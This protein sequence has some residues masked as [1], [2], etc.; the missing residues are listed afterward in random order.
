MSRDHIQV[1]PVVPQDWS[2][3]VVTR[4]WVSSRRR[5]WL[6]FWYTWSTEVLSLLSQQ[7]LRDHYLSVTTRSSYR[8][9][10]EGC[11]SRKSFFQFE[12][13]IRLFS[14]SFSD[15]LTR[16]TGLSDKVES[17]RTLGQCLWKFVSGTDGN[18]KS[19]QSP[20]YKTF[21]S[22]VSLSLYFVN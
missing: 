11:E 18:R 12:P 13:L 15:R 1:L 14:G 19:V 17:D 16:L 21:Q 22:G 4:N 20:R 2:S 5:R 8:P 6:V 9:E 3:E 10:S 7:P